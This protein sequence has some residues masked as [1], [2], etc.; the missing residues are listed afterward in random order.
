MPQGIVQ[1]LC[2]SHQLLRGA[3]L[4]SATRCT[5]ITIAGGDPPIK[6]KNLQ[7]CSSLTPDCLT[8]NLR[9]RQPAYVSCRMVPGTLTFHARTISFQAGQMLQAGSGSLDKQARMSSRWRRLHQ[10]AGKEDMYIYI[11]IYIYIDIHIH[12]IYIYIYIYS[13]EV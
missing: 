1:R 13:K 4:R 12:I 11:L 6:P 8:Q 2:R 9:M 3:L 7:R 5:Q 10:V